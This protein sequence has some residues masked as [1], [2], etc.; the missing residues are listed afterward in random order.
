MKKKQKPIP[1]HRAELEQVQVGQKAVAVSQQQGGYML[2]LVRS[3]A[4][5]LAL[6]LPW[7]ERLRLTNDS[8][9]TWT[10]QIGAFSHSAASASLFH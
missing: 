10:R 2:A 8:G 3:F 4:L 5:W 1:N 6:R 9:C 7:N